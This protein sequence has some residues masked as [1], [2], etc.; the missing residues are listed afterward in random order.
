MPKRTPKPVPAS[1]QK[2]YR[3]NIF[4]SYS[5]EN[6][7]WVQE[8]LLPLLEQAGLSVCIDYRDFEIGRP[9]IVNMEWAVENSRHTLIVLTPNWIE[10]QWTDFRKLARCN[11]GPG[12]ADESAPPL[13][14]RPC[15]PPP[16]IA[17]PD[18]R[19]PDK[20]GQSPRAAQ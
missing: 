17:H 5:H 11:L 16:R 14:L 6:R 3:F 2:N 19:G 12:W 18:L 10:S 13:M 7:K 9:S 20:A 8:T 1:P 15:E 4:I